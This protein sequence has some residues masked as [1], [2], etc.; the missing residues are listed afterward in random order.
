[1]FVPNGSY[2]VDVSI[3]SFY[4][5][6]WGGGGVQGCRFNLK[7][8]DGGVSQEGGGGCWRGQERVCGDF[9]GG[10]GQIFFGGLKIPTGTFFLLENFLD[11]IVVRTELHL[12]CTQIVL[13]FFFEMRNCVVR[14]GS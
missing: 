12:H 2:L 6:C 7:S 11:S 13:A 1:M 3:F 4:F 5:F 10:G 8:Q 9:R 14:Q